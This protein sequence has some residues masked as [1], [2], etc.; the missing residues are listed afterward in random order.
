MRAADSAV[1]YRYYNNVHCWPVKSVDSDQFNIVNNI[2]P[3]ICETVACVDPGQWHCEQRISCSMWQ[4]GNIRY[5]QCHHDLDFSLHCSV[6]QI[7]FYTVGNVTPIT[8]YTV[9]SVTDQCLHHPQCHIDQ[10]L[11]CSQCH[12]SVYIPS[13][14]SHWS[15]YTPFTV[16]H[17]SLSTLFT[18]SQ[19]SAYTI[20]NV[21]LIS[22]YTV[23]SV[24]DQC[25]QHPQWHIEQYL[26]CS[27]CHRSVP[28]LSTMSHWSV[29][30]IL[31]TVP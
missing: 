14:M 11:H 22:I 10:H 12:W 27:Q 28:T 9:H 31:F 18:V 6:S 20:H 8:I 24:T 19:I 2:D 16:S 13:T 15:V 17:R 26:H 5:V 21:T 4:F 1:I 23:R 3:D 7:S 25:L 29:S 30:S